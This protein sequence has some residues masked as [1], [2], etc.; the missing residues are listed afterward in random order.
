MELPSGDQTFGD[1]SEL[2][3]SRCLSLSSGVTTLV[4]MS[5]TTGCITDDPSYS[6]NRRK[7]SLV[8][9]GDQLGPASVYFE[10]VICT[11]F[12]PSASA[13]QMPSSVK[14]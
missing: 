3:L 11:G 4:A 1:G 12:D 13:T 5:A 9:S 2:E 8:P 7:V 6:T 14:S 10:S